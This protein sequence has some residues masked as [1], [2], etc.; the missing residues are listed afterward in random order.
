MISLCGHNYKPSAWLRMV[1]FMVL[2][3]FLDSALK[4]LFS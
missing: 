2:H 1:G 4:D 3:Y